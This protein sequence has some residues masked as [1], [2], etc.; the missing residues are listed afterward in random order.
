MTPERMQE[1]IDRTD[2]VRKEV[3]NWC[4]FVGQSRTK[5]GLET[6]MLLLRTEHLAQDLLKEL[7]DE[8]LEAV[9]L[10]RAWQDL[11]SDNPPEF[12]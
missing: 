3:R 2:S 1:L 7:M 11:S 12:H 5:K 10:R 8:S 9:M 4:C 6:A